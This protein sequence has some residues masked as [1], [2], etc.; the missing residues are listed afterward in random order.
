VTAMAGLNMKQPSDITVSYLVRLYF[1]MFLN[2]ILNL[3]LFFLNKLFCLFVSFIVGVLN[4]MGVV[5]FSVPRR[6][7][8]HS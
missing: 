7:F 8:V 3:S 6:M 5:C 2:N 4:R 1:L